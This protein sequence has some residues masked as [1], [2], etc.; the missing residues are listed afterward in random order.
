MKSIKLDL[1]DEALEIIQT[2][3]KYDAADKL[4]LGPSTIEKYKWVINNGLIIDSTECDN[5]VDDDQ[6]DD[7]LAKQQKSKQRMQDNLRITR[8]QVREDNRLDNALLAHHESLISILKDKPPHSWK[9][10]LGKPL[11]ESEGVG[12]LQ[13]S[14]LHMNEI[15][16]LHNNQYDFTVASKR[17]QYLVKRAKKRFTDENV[18]KVLIVMSGD[19][20]N[21]D[22]RRDELLSMAMNRSKSEIATVTLL[23]QVILDIANDFMVDIVSV[24]GNES[25]VGEKHSHLD[26]VA[27]D[28]YDWTITEIL[29]LLFRECD[30]VSFIDIPNPSEVI[31][32]V[33]GHNFLVIHGDT[34]GQNT[35]HKTISQLKTKIASKHGVIIDYVLFGHIHSGYCSELFSRSGSLVGA[36]SY[37]DGSLNLESK[38]SQNIYIVKKN[39]IEPTLIDLQNPVDVVGYN[40]DETLKS[41]NAK[42]AKKAERYKI[43]NMKY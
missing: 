15:V 4:D 34:I 37:S 16:E 28:N 9:H 41:Y 27:T 18:T 1:S 21:S 24:V 5:T 31:I 3:N 29:K 6:Y 2:N 19:M 33:N 42:S 43:H 25:R 20:L 14:D 36:N 10:E 40:I 11:P 12:V 8:K 23:E 26:L 38:A 39:Y 7:Y 17:L 30:R 35:I 32:K 22:R 13:L